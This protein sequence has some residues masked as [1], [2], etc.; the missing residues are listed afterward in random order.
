MTNVAPECFCLHFGCLR[1]LPCDTKK[2]YNLNFG[3]IH[4]GF[5]NLC[6]SFGRLILSVRFYVYPGQE[7]SVFLKAD[8]QLKLCPNFPV[9]Q[10][11]LQAVITQK[12]GGY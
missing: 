2:S 10:A 5:I 6:F 9:F 11:L 1:S 4:L 3:F 7:N 12:T 8:L